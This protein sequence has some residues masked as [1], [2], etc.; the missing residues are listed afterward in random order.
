M[1][2]SSSWKQADFSRGF[3]P[4]A[5]AVCASGIPADVLDARRL[6]GKGDYAE[7]GGIVIQAQLEKSMRTRYIGKTR[8][9]SDEKSF[10][11]IEQSG[12]GASIIIRYAHQRGLFYALSRVDL[13]LEEGLLPQGGA[14]DYP[15]FS[16]RGYIEGF[17]G[18]PWSFEQKKEMLAFAASQRMNT[19]YYAPK[20]DPYHRDLWR[21]LYPPEE[22]ARL[23]QLA[24]L[25]KNLF[26]DFHYCIAP[27][28][29]MRYSDPAEFDTL[30][31]KIRQV[32]S[33]GVRHFGLLLDD[34]GEELAF[35]EDRAA[36]GEMVNAHSDLACRFYDALKKL[37]NGAILTVCPMQYFGRGDEYYIS[38]LGCALPPEVRVFWTGRDI[39]SRELTSPEAVRFAEHT[40][41]RPLY[42]DNY[43]VNDAEMYNEMH[44]GPLI[45]RDPGLYRYAA[46]LIANCMEY[47]EC[48]KIPLVTIA[49]YLWD[50][51]S[52][53]PEVSWARALELV[54]GKEDAAVFAVFADH[55]RT[56]CLLDAN[57]PA[58]QKVFASV[59][60]AFRSG[61]IAAALA[62]VS[63]YIETASRCA[64]WLKKDGAL[65]RELARWSEKFYIF[66]DIVAKLPETA[67]SGE[68]S[69]IR[70]LLALI[71][72]Y[73]AKPAVLTKFNIKQELGGFLHLS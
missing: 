19:H 55:L 20:D 56:S 3:T 41:H 13:L 40:M 7:T 46:G 51:E 65:S 68:E 12:A 14:E 61:D 23:S 30:M 39:C 27:G 17:Y 9:L 70:E 58:M 11:E 4:A 64:Q 1:A 32:Y 60:Q 42:W 6:S 36:F 37:D 2:V 28:L 24:S 63:S 69:D 38:A 31:A 8:S 26:V 49:D 73:E 33:A 16:V 48:S 35:E 66:T 57:S 21:E 54:A 72:A 67:L 34:I 45:G 53:E 52:Y 50:S 15:L 22:L 43:P 29:D 47:C 10:I 44:L 62:G 5:N 71:D 59:A 18:Q 25:S